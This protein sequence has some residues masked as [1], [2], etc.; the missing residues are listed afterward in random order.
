AHSRLCVAFNRDSYGQRRF[1]RFELR[2]LNP[3]SRIRTRSLEWRALFG[4]RLQRFPV[5]VRSAFPAPCPWK[6]YKVEM[7][8]G[9]KTR[10]TLPVSSLR[11]ARSSGFLPGTSRAWERD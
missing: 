8:Y 3:K 1:K 2:F 5:S 4:T 9:W 7:P 6:D 11:A 10:H